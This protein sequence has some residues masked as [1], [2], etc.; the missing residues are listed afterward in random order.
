MLIAER[1]A[2]PHRVVGREVVC[3]TQVDSTNEECRRRAAGE[4]QN[5][6]AV[7]ADGQTRGRGRRGR[8]FQSLPGRGLYLS[9]LLRPNAPLSEV[10]A[11]TAWTAVAV[12]RG[13][14]RAA[15]VRAD[16]K[17]PNDILLEGKKLCGILTE[18]GVGE[19]GT[20]DYVIIGIGVNVRQSEAEFGPELA[21]IATSLA[22]HG[23]TLGR[24]ALAEALLE[25]LDALYRDFPRESAAYLAEYRRR[26]VTLGREV[27]VL[28][29][30][31]ATRATALD[32]DD[33]FGL[34]IGLPDGTRQT[35]TSGE[36]SVRGLLGYG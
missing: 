13:L 19:S 24:G 36:V 1:L 2:S 31:A 12:C 18:L 16:I 8:D 15:G 27:T 22:Q 7:C 6:L 17:W 4:R 5:G 25:E 30:S 14:E 29:G 28:R 32:I 23:V 9:V 34:V 21:P 10:S 26:C 3:L 35:V 11:I 33:G 20:L